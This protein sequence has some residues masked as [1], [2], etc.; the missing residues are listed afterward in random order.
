MKY[1]RIDGRF[2]Y[3]LVTKIQNVFFICLGLAMTAIS[4]WYYFLDSVGAHEPFKSPVGHYMG[5]QIV[6]AMG[7]TP[8]PTLTP[9]NNRLESEIKDV[10]EDKADEAIKV[11]QC[12]S[13][14]RLKF[15][16]DGLNKNGTV[17][18]GVFQINSQV[19]GINRKWLNNVTINVR[20]AKQLYDE[21]GNWSAWK[22]SKHCH[23]L[24]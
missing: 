24:N 19:H 23:G 6:L 12:E 2:T 8:T 11:A 3:K 5:P 7:I 13:G 18:C 4:G 10:F 1:R 17:D 14:L 16:N 15:C 22:S 21:H 9:L 20:V